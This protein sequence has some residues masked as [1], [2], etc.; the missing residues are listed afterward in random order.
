MTSGD[1]DVEVW[2]SEHAPKAHPEGE[3]NVRPARVGDVAK[4]NN[5]ARLPAKPFTDPGGHLAF[6]AG[7][8]ATDE[9]LV[10][11][12]HARRS[13]HDFAVHC[14][15]CLDDVDVWKFALR[16]FAERIGVAD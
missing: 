13:D 4:V 12:R 7:V 16:L 2:C 15:E 10:V 9:Q 6:G 1:V 11:A 14:I 5:I 3:K 8:I